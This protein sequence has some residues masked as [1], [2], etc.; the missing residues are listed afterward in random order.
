MRRDSIVDA[1]GRGRS[2]R[3]SRRSRP[4]A[5]TPITSSQTSL[6]FKDLPHR[7][8]R[9]RRGS[10]R[11]SLPTTQTCAWLRI[12][13]GVEEASFGRGRLAPGAKSAV[14]D[15]ED[16]RAG[17]GP[18]DRRRSARCAP[19]ARGATS[20][21]PGHGR[22]ESRRGRA[23]RARVTVCRISRSSSSVASFART[24]TLR[25]P[26]LLDQRQR[27]LLGACSDRQH[28]DHRRHAEDD[29]Q[30][31]QQGAQ[32]VRRQARERGAGRL[33][34]LHDGGSPGGAS[35]TSSPGSSTPRS[36]PL[37]P[38]TARR[39]RLHRGAKRSLLAHPT[40]GPRRPRSRSPAEAP[41]RLRRARRD[42]AWPRRGGQAS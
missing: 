10:R 3:R 32:L 4:A 20:S 13:D 41:R 28:R 29:A 38:P 33:A 23:A 34:E 12:V 37:A 18:R 31:R 14:I 30:R 26:E 5:S 6:T 16:S 21:M 17:R 19:R 24:M 40:H 27:R 2:R 42:R 7:G 9:I 35:A 36:P 22:R 15:A 39:S 1:L 11:T 25:S 8:A